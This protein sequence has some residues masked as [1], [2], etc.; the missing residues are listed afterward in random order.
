[1]PGHFFSDQQIETALHINLMLAWKYHLKFPQVPKD[2]FTSIGL[3]AIAVCL[4]AWKKKRRGKKDNFG[5]FAKICIQNSYRKY[6]SRVE[7]KQYL[8]YLKLARVS[9]RLA[10]TSIKNTEQED[11]FALPGSFR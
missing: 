9:K 10:Y 7:C 6:L 1:L 3:V 8:L 5:G 4:N 11:S 2:E